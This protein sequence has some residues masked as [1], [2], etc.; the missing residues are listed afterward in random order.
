VRTYMCVCVCVCV[1]VYVCVC[2]FVCA[3]AYMCLRVCLGA[4]TPREMT[5]YTSWIRMHMFTRTSDVVVC[6]CTRTAL[7]S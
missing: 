6:C 7:P 4:E 3:R 2:V 5:S 1:C